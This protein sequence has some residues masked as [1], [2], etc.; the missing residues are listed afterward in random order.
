MSLTCF[1][2]FS[3]W[4]A[5]GRKL[6][7]F[8]SVAISGYNRLAAAWGGITVRIRFAVRDVLWM[9]L[10]AAMVCGWWCDHQRMETQREQYRAEVLRLRTFVVPSGSGE[11]PAKSP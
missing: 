4:S 6:R 10:V 1:G 7:V 8:D 3:Q 5:D 9:V 11:T 2:V